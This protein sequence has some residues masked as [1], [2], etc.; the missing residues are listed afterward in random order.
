ML[1]GTPTAEGEYTVPVVATL[2]DYEVAVD[3]SLKVQGVLPDSIMKFKILSGNG[4]THWGYSQDFSMGSVTYITSDPYVS[5]NG[6][7]RRSNGETYLT[8]NG[9][10]PG[11][12]NNDY[13]S[14]LTLDCGSSGSWKLSAAN[15]FNPGS[16]EV[17]WSGGRGLNP[18]IG[19]YYTCE[20]RK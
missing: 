7:R 9:R 14:N 5:L 17:Y 16:V 3:M 18:V 20:L 19:Q 11:A 15:Y 6:L 8:L 13:Y 2:G 1:Q 10:H 12:L 4:G